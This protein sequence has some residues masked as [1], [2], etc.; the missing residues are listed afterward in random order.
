[1]IVVNGIA[2]VHVLK[3]PGQH[4]SNV[5]QKNINQAERDDSIM[6][7]ANG[8]FGNVRNKK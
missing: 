1:V 5:L 7:H 2:A 6:L 3:M 4:H 8:V